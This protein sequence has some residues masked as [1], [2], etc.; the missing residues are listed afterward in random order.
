MIHEIFSWEQIK[1]SMRNTELQ[2]GGEASRGK[3]C[4]AGKGKQNY[5][6]KTSEREINENDTLL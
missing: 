6:I 1:E 5:S 2:A 3:S 4:S